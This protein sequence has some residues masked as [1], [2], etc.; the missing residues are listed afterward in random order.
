M[1]VFVV[2]ISCRVREEEK[3]GESVTT[4]NTIEGNRS[5]DESSSALDGGSIPDNMVPDNNES[6]SIS[7]EGDNLESSKETGTTESSKDIPVSFP[8]HENELPILE[9]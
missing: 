8:D 3:Q 1:A 7:S 4:S 9:D 2:Y 5:A 6:L